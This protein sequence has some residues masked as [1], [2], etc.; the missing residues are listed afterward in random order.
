MIST[1][2]EELLDACQAKGYSVLGL[3]ALVR[4]MNEAKIYRFKRQPKSC[5]EYAV[6][7]PGYGAMPKTKN[8][9]DVVAI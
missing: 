3:C 4:I 5:F 2:Y 9:I 1:D 8:W 6:V 7:M